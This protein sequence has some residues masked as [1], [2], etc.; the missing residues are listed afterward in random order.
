MLSSMKKTIDS[1]NIFCRFLFKK[2]L[3]LSI[4]I[5]TQKSLT[6]VSG[7]SFVISYE[8]VNV[9]VPNRF[10]FYEIKLYFETYFLIII[11]EHQRNLLNFLQ[12]VLWFFLFKNTIFKY[13]IM[14]LIYHYSY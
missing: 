9:M 10:F 8:L 12:K 14:Y 6:I 11:T 4:F 13:I 3:D 7:R 1:I 2:E 5:C